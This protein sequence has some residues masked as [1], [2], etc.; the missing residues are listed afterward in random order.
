MKW[1]ESDL[2]LWPRAHFVVDALTLCGLDTDSFTRVFWKEVS[3]P[4]IVEA[5]CGNCRRSDSFSFSEVPA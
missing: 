5:V 3:P 1:M 2:A 4:I